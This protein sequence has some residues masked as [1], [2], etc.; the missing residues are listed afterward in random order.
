MQKTLV[1]KYSIVVKAYN[2]NKYSGTYVVNLKHEPTEEDITSALVQSK[3]KL[4][5]GT[6]EATIETVYEL[7]KLETKNETNN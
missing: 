3:N 2:F 4:P 1:K 6:R 5:W 7:V